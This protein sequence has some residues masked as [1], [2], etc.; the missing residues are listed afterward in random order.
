MKAACLHFLF[1]LACAGAVAVPTP[2]ECAPLVAPLPLDDRQQ[3]SGQRKFIS[4]FTDSSVY[5]AILR[6]TE[7][8]RVNLSAATHND[9]DM[10]LYEEMLMNGTCYGTRLNVSIDGNVASAKIQDISS[11]FHLLPTC[12]GCQVLSIN[13]TARNLKTFLEAFNLHIDG[14]V[15]D[16][17]GI[18]AIYLFGN[19]VRDSDMERFKKQAGCL[20]FSGEPDFT[21]DP[22]KDF[23]DGHKVVMI[24]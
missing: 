6:V 8:T 20:G 23:C 21:M 17:I 24:N 10:L 9:K 1:A 11:R 2:D 16:E 15:N 22:E 19:D 3:L 7:S 13:S 14:A 4:G 12:E 18:R 5:N